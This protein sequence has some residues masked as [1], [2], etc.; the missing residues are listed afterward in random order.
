MGGYACARARALREVSARR[1][2]CERRKSSYQGHFLV[3][4][5]V[6]AG[7][8]SLPEP[9]SLKKASSMRASLQPIIFRAYFLELSM[10]KPPTII[11]SRI[12]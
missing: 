1:A 12:K 9:S 6:V 10:M 8:P 3:A 5:F 2:L 11:S 4:L 7:P